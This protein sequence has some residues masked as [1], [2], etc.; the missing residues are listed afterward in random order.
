MT[1]NDTSGGWP[2]G[3]KVTKDGRLVHIEEFTLEN[4]IGWLGELRKGDI[5][6]RLSKNQ[7][8][9][10][11]IQTKIP[12]GDVH[13]LYMTMYRLVEYFLMGEGFTEEECKKLWL[14]TGNHKPEGELSQDV[15]GAIELR[16]SGEMD[17]TFKAM[18]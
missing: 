7:E 18:K 13:S 8:T 12:N 15:M 3:H 1:A 16:Y 9:N 5:K 11:L 6:Y 10:A 2:E 4:L 17:L 14:M